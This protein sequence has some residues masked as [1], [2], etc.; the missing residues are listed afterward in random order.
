MYVFCAR[1]EYKTKKKVIEAYPGWRVTPVTGGWLAF[2][3]DSDYET[4]R[5]Q[6]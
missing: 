4:W 3:W 6:K 5:K 2:E 1:D